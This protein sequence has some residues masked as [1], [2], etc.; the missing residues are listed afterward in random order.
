MKYLFIF[1]SI[2]LVAVTAEATTLE[3]SQPNIVFVMTDDQG[4]N[5]SCIGHPEVQTPHIDRFAEKS[6]RFTNFY[7]S[8]NCAP[9][10]A[11]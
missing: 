5:L 1:V 11:A 6:L 3:N 9:T 8:P 10:R 7:V 2:T 4:M